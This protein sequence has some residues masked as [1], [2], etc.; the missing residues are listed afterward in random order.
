MREYNFGLVGKER[1][2]LVAAVS[3]ILGIQSKYCAAPNYEYVIGDYTVTRDG[4]LIGPEDISLM[5]WLANKG[6]EV[7]KEEAQSEA[8]SYQET[9][10]EPETNPTAAAEAKTS[11]VAVAE[12]DTSPEPA[13]EPDT[14]PKPATEPDASPEAVEEAETGPEA[15]TEL[16]T[17]PEAATEPE[18]SPEMATE[19]EASPNAAIKLDASPEANTEP[20]TSPEADNVPDGDTLR[21][22]SSSKEEIV[23]EVASEPETPAEPDSMTLTIEYPLEGMTDEAIINLRKLITAKE[24]LLKMALET[25][26]LPILL[27]E[28]SLKFPWLRGE[29]NGDTA[30]AYAQLISCLCETAKRKKRVNAQIISTD[31]PRFCMRTWLV[32]IGMV[33]AE[34]DFT[35]KLVCGKLPGDSGHR[36]SGHNTMTTRKSSVGGQRPTK[37]PIISEEARAQIIGIRDSGTE[38]MLNIHDVGELAKERGYQELV[39]LIETSPISYVTFILANGQ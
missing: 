24:P 22:E 28:N 30:K 31:N 14:G 36:F 35:R 20:D 26:E 18:T 15:V 12:P 7:A 39:E 10:A 3:D 25:D 23:A 1:K 8:D 16:D 29:I 6:F 5:A 13:T 27:T 11:P 37:Q 2:T 32:S 38:K 21:T 33:G 19:P 9:V 34:Y 4:T 17:G